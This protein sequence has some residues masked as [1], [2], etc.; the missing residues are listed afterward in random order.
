M[1]SLRRLSTPI[2]WLFLHTLR[3]YTHLHTIKISGCYRL[4]PGWL[5]EQSGDDRDKGTVVFH[6]R[7]RARS[8]GEFTRSSWL[9]SFKLKSKSMHLAIPI[10]HHHLLYTWSETS[11]NQCF[12]SGSSKCKDY[13]IKMTSSSHPFNHRGIRRQM[14]SNN[15]T[16]LGINRAKPLPAGDCNRL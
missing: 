8:R 6:P 5:R 12:N 3:F 9:V 2:G 16:K 1:S 14:R 11:S 7:R 15:V 4:E 10:I 13:C